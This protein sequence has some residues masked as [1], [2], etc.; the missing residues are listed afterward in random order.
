MPAADQGHNIVLVQGCGLFIEVLIGHGHL[1]DVHI[2]IGIKLCNDLHLSEHADTFC[3]LQQEIPCSRTGVC[4]RQHVGDLFQLSRNFNG[5]HIQSEGIIDVHTLVSVDDLINLVVGGVGIGDFTQPGQGT[6]AGGS[7]VEVEVGL[8]LAE[9]V[10]GDLGRDS[11]VSHQV[12]VDIHIADT[13]AFLGGKGQVLD[14]AGIS[15]CNT[16]Q[17]IVHVD[18][19][20]IALVG[21]QQGQVNGFAVDGRNA[22]LLESQGIG[23]DHMQGLLA[24]D[25]AVHSQLNGNLTVCNSQELAILVDG[26]DGLVRNL[27][28]RILGQGC[29]VTGVADTDSRH[30]QGGVDG[31]IVIFRG[32]VCMVKFLGGLGSGNDHQRGSDTTGVAIGGTVGN[33]QGITALRLGQEGGG[34]AAV[35]VDCFHA[36][37]VQHDLGNFFHGAAAGEG[38]LTAIQ[39]HHNNLAV[40]LD[41]DCG[42]AGA[43]AGVVGSLAHS[44]FTITDQHCAETADSFLDLILV[45]GVVFLGADHGAAVFQDCEEAVVVHA[46]PFFAFHHQQ[47]AGLAGGDV[48]AVSVGCHDDIEVFDVFGAGRIGVVFHHG[49]CLILNTLGCPTLRGVIIVVVGH[50]GHIIAR[51]IHSCQIVDD[52]LFVSSHGILDAL[53]NAGSQDGFGV[54]EH[55]VIFVVHGLFFFAAL[56]FAAFFTGIAGIAFQAVAALFKQVIGKG[57]ADSHAQVGFTGQA[58]V[59]FQNLQ[60]HI[61]GISIMDSLAHIFTGLQTTEA[62]V[63][64]VSAPV[65]IGQRFG[66]VRLHNGAEL[67]ACL[68]MVVQVVGIHVAIEVIHAEGIVCIDTE[69]IL[70]D[71]GSHLVNGAGRHIA[72]VLAV[73]QQVTKIACPAAQ[74]CSL[75]CGNI[76]NVQRTEHVAKVGQVT[77]GQPEIINDNVAQQHGGGTI[78][79][80][81]L[82]HIAGESGNFLTS[83]GLPVTVVVTIDTGTDEVDHQLAGGLVGGG[84]IFVCIALQH[85]QIG[86]KGC[87]V[88]N[89][90]LLHHYLRILSLFLALRCHNGSRLH[91]AEADNT[92]QQQSQQSH[93]QCVFHLFASFLTRINIVGSCPKGAYFPLICY[94]ILLYLL[95]FCNPNSQIIQRSDTQHLALK[96]SRF[97]RFLKIIRKKKQA[98]STGLPCCRLFAIIWFLSCLPG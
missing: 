60:T 55:S 19:H 89:A 58:A 87:I 28:D 13:G 29:G 81:L 52:L 79:C 34:T 94:F 43:A 75:N 69:T 2:Q 46:V 92:C 76:S 86:H 7:I 9:Q 57:I 26:A 80:I 12:G 95:S 88:G 50:D 71:V 16:G 77:V 27:P 14:A 32:N 47:S 35:Q 38:S 23:Y 48:K 63:H 42:T 56:V 83:Q 96:T 5:S 49:C 31:Q 36:A 11:V 40:S 4:T 67:F 22:A 70:L 62:V 18:A 85:L 93:G 90:G 25:S 61:G 21:S 8:V 37:C 44:H 24:H 3:Q 82:F 20:H 72:V 15:V 41:A 59:G 64:E 65:S 73:Q 39:N 91:Q 10:D 84:G 78:G 6:V 66:E 97:H 68:H 30:L 1:R 33:L 74:V 53:L 45:G 54:G 17:H 98:G 51:H